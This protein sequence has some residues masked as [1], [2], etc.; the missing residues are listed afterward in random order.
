MVELGIYEHYK[1]GHYEVIAN[2]LNEADEVPVVIYKALYD[3][4]KS[5]IW[6]RAEEEFLEDVNLDGQRTSR[7]KRIK[8]HE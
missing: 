2:G 3:N 4:D 6:V 1:G 8:H 5:Q 7:F